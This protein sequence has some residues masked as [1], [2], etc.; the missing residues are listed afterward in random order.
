[1]RNI[2]ESK[3]VVDV[4]SGQ[5][6]ENRQVVMTE[7]TGKSSQQWTIIYKKDGWKVPKVGDKHRG[8]GLR[9]GKD[10][11]IIST[12]GRQRYLDFNSESRNLI[13]KTQNGNKSQ[14]WY[15]DYK[16]KTIR[17]RLNNNS[18]EIS[19]SGNGKNIQWGSTNSKW[20]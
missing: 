11:Y 9:V 6:T 5:D 3:K 19:S 16:T 20:W 8:S 13:I 7:F 10:F 4:Q 12:F 2:K 14:K 17:S 1:M 18:L 15:F